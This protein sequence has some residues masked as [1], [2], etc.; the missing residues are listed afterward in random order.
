MLLSHT[1]LAL[2]WNVW[3]VMHVHSPWLTEL[4]YRFCESRA[5]GI[6]T[7]IRMEQ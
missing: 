6:P 1:S 2:T 5:E 3:L 4:K 7:V